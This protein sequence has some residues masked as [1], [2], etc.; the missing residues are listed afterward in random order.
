ML[1]YREGNDYRPIENH[2]FRDIEIPE[3][4]EIWSLEDFDELLPHS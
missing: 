3:P 4:L 1:E 2:V